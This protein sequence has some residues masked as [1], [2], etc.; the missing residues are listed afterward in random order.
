MAAVPSI[1]RAFLVEAPRRAPQAAATEGLY[2][3]HAAKIQ[4]YCHHQLG[5]REEAEDA[6]QTTFMNAFRALGRGVVPEAESAWLFK[7]AENVCLSRR[8]S[9]W[10]RGRIESPSDF[11]V[12]EEI[13]PGP[14]RQQDELIGIEDA[15][16]SMPE[17]QRRA[18]LLREW[19]GLSY[20]EIAEELEVSQSA[21]ETLIFR[22]RRSLAQG[23]EQPD[24]L[25]K[26]KRK[27]FRRAL[28]AFDL[29]TAAA[30]LKA[31]LAGSAA[32]KATAA[33]VAVTA[34]AGTA[35]TVGQE[36]ESKRQA[37]ERLP[38]P[39]LVAVAPASKAAPLGTASFTSFSSAQASVASTSADA[40]N[41]AAPK[42][43]SARSEPRR[44]TAPARKAP[45]RLAPA[46][47]AVA[48]AFAPAPLAQ[49]PEAAPASA[50]DVQQ[51]AQQPTL[52]PASHP[53]PGPAPTQTKKE[54][55]KGDDRVDP[56]VTL[57]P[58]VAT[59][60]AEPARGNDRPKS[61]HPKKGE[62]PPVESP[63]P[64]SVTAPAPEPVADANGKK[65]RGRDKDKR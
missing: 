65:E 36:L 37:Q 18:I 29:G 38:A 2:E 11:D 21:V 12:I 52:A 25:K 7:I 45:S 15:L 62:K 55:G 33:A 41:D 19:Q 39:A 46:G 47:P 5:S 61:E 35:A 56:V 53:Q 27:S 54:K 16:A 17:Q 63:A 8:R 14:S 44:V 26:P 13:V 48:A 22:A 64:S 42:P 3:R 20:R 6:V 58:P 32:V 40:K 43:A 60:P 57:Q 10:R 51:V 34:A 1:G 49:V 28:H 23:L 31:L 30:A 24:S 9:S 50:P 59:A 4:S